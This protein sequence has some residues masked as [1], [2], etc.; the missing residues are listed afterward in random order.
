[1]ENQEEIKSSSVTNVVFEPVNDQIPHVNAGTEQHINVGHIECEPTL[2]EVTKS[3]GFISTF[4]NFIQST[5]FYK[6]IQQTA[7]NRRVSQKSVAKNFFTHVLGTIGDIGEII[8]NTLED[9]ILGVLGILT[10]ILV[11]GTQLICN[12]ARGLLRVVT[13]NNT[14]IQ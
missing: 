10:N 2:E 11:A 5:R 12:T 1:M 13:L 14:C 6:K 4:M 7:T 9:L 3:K 8:F